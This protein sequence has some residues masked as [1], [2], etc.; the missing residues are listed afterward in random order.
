MPHR[1]SLGSR[2]ARHGIRLAGAGQVIGGPHD[3]R[4]PREERMPETSTP[5][6]RPLIEADFRAWMLEFRRECGRPLTEVEH[7]LARLVHARGFMVGFEVGARDTA[8]N[9]AELFGVEQD[10]EGAQE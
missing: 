1:R 6:V 9:L 2:I 5:D 3:Q 10:G 7:A 4:Q 8:E